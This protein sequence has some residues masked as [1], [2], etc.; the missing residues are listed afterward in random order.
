VVVDD[1][2]ASKLK[3]GDYFRHTFAAKPD[4]QGI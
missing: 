4:W 1:A 3:L 2:A